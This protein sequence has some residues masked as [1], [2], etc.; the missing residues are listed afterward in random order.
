MPDGYEPNTLPPRQHF[1]GASFGPFWGV[2]RAIISDMGVAWHKRLV[3]TSWAEQ[4]LAVIT[5]PEKV[6]TA[7]DFLS[8]ETSLVCV[9]S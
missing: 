7:D 4:T 3:K 1:V 6:T 8:M 5:N 9:E 2:V